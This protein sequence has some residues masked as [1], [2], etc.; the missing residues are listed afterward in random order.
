MFD[1]HKKSVWRKIGGLGDRNSHL[2]GRASGRSFR[3]CRCLAPPID[4]SSE[5]IGTSRQRFLFRRSGFMKCVFGLAG[6]VL[7]ASSIAWG[8]EASGPN[9]AQMARDAAGKYRPASPQEVDSTRRELNAALSRLDALLK[10]SRPEYD[11]GWRKYLRWDELTQQA[12][13]PEGVDPRLADAVVG[14]MLAFEKGLAMPQFV[15]VRRAL[16][17]HADAVAAAGDEKQEETYKQQLEALA[18]SLEKYEQDRSPEEGLAIARAVG[19]LSRRGQAPEL[20]AAVQ[21][22]FDQPNVHATI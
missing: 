17:A 4:L 7:V 1:L 21:K 6:V 3:N 11:A 2:G 15:G 9:L 22:R 16:A 18:A 20:V 19:W 12:Q 10:N 5:R 14:K 8:Q 13:R